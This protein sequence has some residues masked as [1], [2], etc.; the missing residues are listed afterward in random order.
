MKR[1]IQYSKLGVRVASRL[2]KRLKTQD[3]GKQGNIKKI[4]NLGGGIA[5]CPVSLPEIKLWYQQSKNKR[6]QISS[7]SCPIQLYW[8]SVFCSKYFVQGR[9]NIGLNSCQSPS[10][11]NFL[12]FCIS[13]KF[14]LH[15]QGKYKAS[16]SSY[17]FNFSGLCKQ[18]FAY[19]VQLEN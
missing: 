4:S 5:Q 10:N 14:F 9:P 1:Y 18:Y 19:L 2:G 3:F 17:A 7:F 8:I 16:P 12:T 13:S 6:K 11:L 15:L